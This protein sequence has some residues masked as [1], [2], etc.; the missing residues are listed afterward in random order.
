MAINKQ[1]KEIVLVFGI[2][3]IQESYALCLCLISYFENIVLNEGK[4]ADDFY[5]IVEKFSR[6]G[7]ITFSV[8]QRSNGSNDKMESPVNKGEYARIPVLPAEDKELLTYAVDSWRK[9]KLERPL[10]HI[11]VKFDYDY[12]AGNYKNLDN[13]QFLAMLMQQVYI[14][15]FGNSIDFVPNK[16][17]KRLSVILIPHTGNFCKF[18]GEDSDPDTSLYL[19]ASQYLRLIAK[20]HNGVIYGCSQPNKIEAVEFK[21]RIRKN[22]FFPLLYL[23]DSTDNYHKIFERS[24]M[25]DKPSQ[26][27]RNG[28]EYRIKEN[29]PR[30]FNKAGD[31][32]PHDAIADLILDE[33]RARLLS[34]FASI[35][36]SEE[37]R[38]MT[39]DEILDLGR[40]NISVFLNEIS[41]YAGECDRFTFALFGYLLFSGEKSKDAIRKAIRDVMRLAHELGDGIRQVVQNSIQHSQYHSCYVSFLKKDV[42]ISPDEFEEQLCVRVTDLNTQNNMTQTFINILKKEKKYDIFGINDINDTNLTIR[43]LISEFKSEKDNVLTAWYTYRRT[44]SSAHIGLTMFNNTLKR[45]KYRELQILS[46]TKYNIEDKNMYNSEETGYTPK[47]IIPG[48]QVYFSLPIKTLEYVSPVNLVQLAN[49][50]SFSEDYT[51]FA[52]YLEYEVSMEI[53]KDEKFELEKISGNLYDFKITD[54]ELKVAAQERWKGFWLNLMNSSSDHDRKIHFCDLSKKRNLVNFLGE[55]D[56]CEI[57]IKGFFSAASLY[58]ID[59][60]LKEKDQSPLCFYFR[61]LPVH[62]IDIFQE[63]SIS[64]S[65]MNFSQHLQ[66]FFSC[67]KAHDTS[68]NGHRPKC[69]LALGNSVG[70]VIQNAYILSFEHGEDGIDAYY[71]TNASD[72][73]SPYKNKL[74]PPDKKILVCPFTV[75]EKT[76]SFNDIP[77]YFKQ[78]EEITELPLV[79]YDINER[80]YKLTDIHMRLGNKVHADSFYELSFLFYRTSVANRVAFYILQKIMKDLKN[81]PDDI[82]FY[83]YA[84]YSQA[85]IISLKEISQIY[86]KKK[87]YYAIYQYNLEFESSIY[88]SG[89]RSNNNDIQI[90]STYDKKNAEGKPSKTTVVQIVPIG[91]TLTTF[92]KMRN[93]YTKD[94]EKYEDSKVIE[95]YNVFLVRDAKNPSSIE[96]ELWKEVDTDNR[97]ITVNTESLTNLINNPYIKYIISRKSNWSSPVQ[98]EKCF[99]GKVNDEV[100]L[101]ETDSTSTVPSL[102]IYQKMPKT[103]DKSETISAYSSSDN[104]LRLSEL[105]GCVYYGHFIRGKNHYQYYIDTQKYI[106]K[107]KIEKELI[108]WLEKEREKDFTITRNEVEITTPVLNI[109][110]SPEHS[111]NV[112]FSQYV[113]TYYFNGTAEIISVNVDKQFRSN[114]IGEHNALNQTIEYLLNKHVSNGFP[115]RF[116]FVDDS[117]ITGWSYH[118]SQTLIRSLIPESYKTVKYNFVFSKCFILVDRLSFATK[119]DYVISPRDNFLSFCKIN[120]SN[121]RTHGD[122]CV[123]CKLEDEAKYLFKRSSTR[124][125]ANYWAKKSLDY[126]PV[127]FDDTKRMRSYGGKK[128]FVR[129]LLTHVVKNLVRK[130]NVDVSGIE[131]IFRIILEESMKP[132]RDENGS[133]IIKGEEATLVRIA[134]DSLEEG[135]TDEKII[136]LIEHTI[137]VLSRPFISYNFEVKTYV[138]RMIINICESIITDQSYDDSKNDEFINKIRRFFI[139]IDHKEDPKGPKLKVFDFV[140]DCLF[141]ALADMKSTYLLR[142]ETIKKVYKFTAK[143]ADYRSSATCTHRKKGI[144]QCREI[145]DSSKDDVIYPCGDSRIRCFWK[146]YAFHIHKIIDSGGDETRSLW[147]ECLFSFGSEHPKYSI[148]M[149][150]IRKGIFLPLFESV[151]MKTNSGEK[152]KQCF[153]EFCMELFFQNSRLLFE[154]IE[155]SIDSI[156]ENDPSDNSYFL[157]N[158]MTM[159]EWDYAWAAFKQSKEIS[160]E[161][162]EMFVFFKEKGN[163]EI[164]IKKKYTDFINTII[165]MVYMKYSIAKNSLCIAL[166]TQKGDKKPFEMKDLEFIAENLSFSYQQN[167]IPQAKYFIKKRIIWALKN[168]LYPDKANNYYANSRLMG[169]GYFLMRFHNNVDNPDATNDKFDFDNDSN[170]Y[171]KPFF[172][173]RFD[174]IA[175]SHEL[176]LGREAQ[177]IETVYMYVSFGFQHGDNDKK[178]VVPVLIMRDILSYRNRIMRI[179]EKDFTSDL[180][181]VDAH[182]TLENAIFKHER[183]VSHTST[184]DEQLPM[185]IWNTENTTETSIVEYDW[186]LF[187]NYTNMQIAKLFNRTLLQ[188]NN[189]ET[190]DYNEGVIQPPKLY[191]KEE[192]ISTDINFSLPAK[193]FMTDILNESD[194]RV[195]LCRE[196]IDIKTVGLD[197][198]QLITPN[199]DYAKGYFNQ[200]YLKCVFFDIFLSC[201]KFWH[202]GAGFLS[203]IQLLKN[204]QE[205]YITIKDEYDK[206]PDNE[207]A[208]SLRSQNNLRCK[209]LLLRNDNKLV[210]INPV[211]RTSNLVLD[212]WQERNEEIRMRFENPYDSFNGRM[213]LFTISNYISGNC[214]EKPEFEY[215]LYKDLCNGWNKLLDEKWEDELSNDSL[216]FVSKLPIFTGR[217]NND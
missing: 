57:F 95:N 210:I 172:I 41:D 83:G 117:I 73:I 135:T 112:G 116:F 76:F 79:N 136:F 37:S 68:S 54:P 23:G 59:R 18:A 137:K 35:S 193:D 86:L 10:Y 94:R 49:N 213:S 63:V 99:P 29:N 8:N 42:Q 3:N 98:C 104:I 190:V 129:L 184:S 187:R 205:E 203:R 217:I 11:R 179:L 38:E 149:K 157:K 152:V 87:I 15:C 109:I 106:T 208:D 82:I 174:N 72:M 115:V 102:Q 200:E 143:Y 133:L 101:V 74:R 55:R 97:I 127:M 20:M 159:R 167:Q 65:L 5:G 64:L 178:E 146:K 43:Q 162:K 216:W 114:F 4:S 171:R 209:I 188:L 71:Y 13:L 30:P 185:T 96:K 194:K 80:G 125:F 211:D 177:P 151:V 22:V 67:V 166:V 191:L 27:I 113:N 69:L 107:K 164:I 168:N 77:Q 16:L 202:E 51:A 192:N 45:C 91:S 201:A 139:M 1:L 204:F 50:N 34:F 207:N 145:A 150:D 121:I 60:P 28:F 105:K 134:F 36:E 141:E 9:E 183:T 161:E 197:D 186:L 176:H 195:R 182:K 17:N 92:D 21:K 44:D 156:R 32:N 131:R 2:E 58:C 119:K 89:Y 155:K 19:I 120:I 198:A 26:T 148:T 31:E 123:G 40:N 111:T 7:Y 140:K 170:A 158:M 160:K 132:C 103:Q 214:N 122:S 24:G 25:P 78:I 144:C 33:A 62:F 173:L 118:R 39:N 169:D 88:K 75:F 181:Q 215:S 46:D 81:V 110:F 6:E 175:I 199:D 212:A 47:Y 147:I 142:K 85:L 138:L 108:L 124:S 93:K 66:V 128:A 196:I 90:Y 56:N 153:K 206:N 84:S 61:N 165:N 14:T 126:R 154:G 12:D 53:W 130:N 189:D 163:S 100:P 48:T 52:N 70:H 180:M